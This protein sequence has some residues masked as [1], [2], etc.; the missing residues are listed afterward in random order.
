MQIYIIF[1]NHVLSEKGASCLLCGLKRCSLIS[2]V[3]RILT[4]KF[5]TTE[6]CENENRKALLT[7]RAPFEDKLPNHC[8]CMFLSCMYYRIMKPSPDPCKCTG[9]SGSVLSA[10][11]HHTRF[12]HRKDYF[13]RYHFISMKSNRMYKDILSFLTNLRIRHRIAEQSHQTFL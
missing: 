4:S 2:V 10:C 11:V 5:V 8:H 3:L 12:I 13:Q 9:Q 6:K 1:S 7:K